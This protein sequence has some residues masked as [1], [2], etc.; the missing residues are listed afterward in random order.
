MRSIIVTGAA[1]GIGKAFVAAYLQDSNN[2]IVAIDK[3]FGDG[4]YLEHN[5]MSSQ[6][7]D[8][9][10]D[11]ATRLSIRR[12]D[13]TSEAALD[14]LSEAL[15][16]VDLVVHCAGTRGL[17]PSVTVNEGLD[18][19]KAETIDVMT[20]DTMQQTFHINTIG[21]FLLLRV[22]IPKLRTSDCPKVVVMGSRMGS[23]DHISSGGGYAYRASKAAIN[24]VV[25]SFSIDFPDVTF[26]ILHPGRVRSNLVGHGIVE[27]GA[28]TAEESVR[29]MLR[30]I[31]NINK[32]HTGKFLDRWGSD[33]P[34]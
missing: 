33:I 27:E 6:T 9:P 34:W 20:V 21:T 13:V 24:V 31:N 14:G 3:D 32:S 12:V 16:S 8:V 10:Q 28:I 2:K 17:V 29:D 18:V 5:Y 30:L 22:V 19:A 4:P 15:G 25:K 26:C 7:I 1:S 23:V 11:L